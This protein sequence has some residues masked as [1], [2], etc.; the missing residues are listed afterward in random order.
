MVNKLSKL[1]KFIKKRNIPIYQMS[2]MA[3]KT[4]EAAW[5]E[6]QVGKTTEINSLE[7]LDRVITGK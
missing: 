4:T 1:E 3:I 6:H 2:A 7:E 5:Q